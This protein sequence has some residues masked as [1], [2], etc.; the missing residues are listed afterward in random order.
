MLR[1]FLDPSVQ[2]RTLLTH[3]PLQEGVT[4][5]FPFKPFKSNTFHRYFGSSSKSLEAGGGRERTTHAQF[6]LFRQR[7]PCGEL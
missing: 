3:V 2:L 6:S 1:V 5:V 7:E 4:G